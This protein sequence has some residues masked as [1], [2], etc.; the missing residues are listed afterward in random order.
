MTLEQ[1]IERKQW[2]LV[3][4]MLLLGVSEVASSLPPESLAALLDLV[5][6]GHVER[7]GRRGHL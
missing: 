3:S 7:G 5:G 2:P 1:A 4:L 6:E